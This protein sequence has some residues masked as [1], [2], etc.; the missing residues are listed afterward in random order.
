M[1][2]D[3]D[4]IRYS[5]ELNLFFLRI[6]KEHAIFAAA[7]LPPRD[8][9]ISYQLLAMKNSFEEL[10]NEAVELSNGN[11][12]PE[13]LASNELVTE[14]TLA[15]ELQTQ[16]LTGLPINTNITNKQ[17]M[18]RP[19]KI[20]KDDRRLLDAVKSINT[21][22]LALIKS[23]IAFLKK[24]QENVKT[25]RAFS[26]TYPTMLEHVI[27]ESEYYEKLL[28]KLENK[29]TI[30]SIREM[31]EAELVWNEIMYEHTTFIRGYLDP[32]EKALFET[33]DKFAKGFEKLLN[34]TEQ[35]PKRPELLPEVTKE[36]YEN[37]KKL[38]AFKYQSTAGI[39]QCKIKSV[40]LPLLSDHVTREANH[41]LRLLKSFSAHK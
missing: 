36:S 35:L 28:R 38:R 24:L 34:K 25:C 7:S 12:S 17:L 29:D 31:I 33:T 1:L 30:D 40:I 8:L 11:I 26:F 13:V 2:S 14:M 5:L 18:L 21:R 15:S 41:Y 6:S 19:G 23:T 20:G 4:Y 9:N 32:S 37:V 39:L 16:F 22:A 3:R 10:L 27:E